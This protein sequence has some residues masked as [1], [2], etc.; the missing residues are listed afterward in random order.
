MVT[1]PLYNYTYDKDYDEFRAQEL[2]KYL[3]RTKSVNDDEKKLQ[4]ELKKID[5]MIKRSEREH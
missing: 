5:Q 4:E 3:K 2:D 1:H